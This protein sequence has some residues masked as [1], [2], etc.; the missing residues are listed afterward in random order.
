MLD[1]IGI[2]PSI[3]GLFLD[4]LMSHAIVL[5]MLLYCCTSL[6]SQSPYPGLF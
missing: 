2:D 6:Y 1:P 3:R 5:L 4:K